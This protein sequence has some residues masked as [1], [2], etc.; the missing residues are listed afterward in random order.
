MCLVKRFRNACLHLSVSSRSIC[1]IVVRVVL[2]NVLGF[3]RRHL[4]MVGCSLV[5]LYCLV[6]SVCV[7]KACSPGISIGG[8]MVFAMV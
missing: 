6:G 7:R 5:C 1:A 4:C 2:F 8:G 3:H